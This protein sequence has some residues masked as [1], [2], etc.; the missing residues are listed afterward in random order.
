MHSATT[1]FKIFQL[2][3][4]KISCCRARHNHSE[5]SRNVTK[6]AKPVPSVE[7]LRLS[8]NHG[9]DSLYFCTSQGSKKTGLQDEA[10]GIYSNLALEGIV[11]WL[12]TF[13]FAETCKKIGRITAGISKKCLRLH[14]DRNQNT[15]RFLAE[16]NKAPHKTLC[17]RS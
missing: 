1:V 10:I 6:I 14:G 3:A 12:R 2:K 4:D 15:Q 8:I 13:N 17:K 11:D 7:L 16:L 9:S 5:R